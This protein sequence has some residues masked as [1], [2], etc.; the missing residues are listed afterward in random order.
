[1]FMGRERICECLGDEGG[2][3]EGARGRWG[4]GVGTRF[5]G[6]FCAQS[7]LGRM[8]GWMDVSTRNVV[9]YADSTY[10]YYAPVFILYRLHYA[11]VLRSFRSL[12]IL[13]NK[14]VDGWYEA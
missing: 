14:L 10:T 6:A 1:M 11:F 4:I 3:G 2:E 7:K 8:D 9:G 5:I 13:E 12:F